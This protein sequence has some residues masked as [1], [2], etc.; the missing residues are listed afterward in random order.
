MCVSRGV[1]MVLFSGASSIDWACGHVGALFFDGTHPLFY[2]L[3]GNQT[4]RAAFLGLPIL[5]PLAGEMFCL[6]APMFR[7]GAV[8]ASQPK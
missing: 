1:L 5:Q 7:V 2:V 3:K 4:K 8:G 6:H